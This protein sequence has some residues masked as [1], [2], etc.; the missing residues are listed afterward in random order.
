VYGD[1]SIFDILDS[2]KNA[3]NIKIYPDGLVYL[4]YE[5]ELKSQGVRGLFSI[6]DKS[7]NRSFIIPPVILPPQDNDFRTDSI[8]QVVDFDLSPEKLYEIAL[9]S[10]GINYSTSII[11]SSSQL[12]YQIAVYFPDFISNS[13]QKPLNQVVEGTGTLPLA[14]YTMHL[15]NNKFNM[16]LVLILKKHSNP[17]AIAPGTSI[18]LSLNFANLEFNYIKGFLGDQS[19]SI[20]AEQVKIPA[21][22]NA[23]QQ[24]SVSLA[25]P[26]ISITTVNENG[27][28]CL[29]DFKT[30]E[31][32]KDDGTSLP[33]T[34]DPAN[35]VSIAYPGVLGT[36]ASTGIA[37]T[38]TKEV[39]DF[40]PSEFYYQADVR[41]NK[42]L[43]SGDNFLL[44]TSKL[45][46]KMNV[47][48]P[49]YGSASGITLRDTINL[50][51]SDVDQSNISSA[52]L[53]LKLI[54]QLPLQGD[55]QF[56]LTD[57]NYNIIGELLPDGQTTLIKG[58][59]VDASGELQS[60]GIYDNSIK[61][62][63][64]EIAQIFKAKHIIVLALL[65]TSEVNGNFPDVK[66][67]ST[68]KL[69][70]DVGISAK[71]KLSVDL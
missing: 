18:T 19:V 56:Y 7:L 24:A 52:S 57:D 47:E 9:K 28:P 43:T 5:Q 14:D 10:G 48:I 53:K 1:L 8:S 6:P 25:Q 59:T 27:V 54:N 51:L 61:L 46:M 15:D 41:I 30:L 31:A 17:V 58:S 38:N 4:A 29:V 45:R 22:K 20:D 21:F 66:F 32:R 3:S 36:S 67:K 64:D 40:A 16:K 55:V 42:G 12:E 69:N 49:L 44:D 35:P 37:I 39:L 11:P 26:L 13:T 50:N 63:D 71:F 65:S 34:L 70:I 68:Y 62:N 2:T 60:P 23:F 33:V